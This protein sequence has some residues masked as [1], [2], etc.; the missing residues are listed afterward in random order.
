MESSVSFMKE[1]KALYEWR[2]QRSE[3][4]VGITQ[5]AGQ[6][7]LEWQ[8]SNVY[9]GDGAGKPKS[10]ERGLDQRETKVSEDV[11]RTNRPR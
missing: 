3:R 9:V 2:S 5:F 7:V 6:R 1:K 8:L 4:P 11:F 10:R